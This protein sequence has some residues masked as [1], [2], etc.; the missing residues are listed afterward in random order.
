MN[1]TKKYSDNKKKSKKKSKKQILDNIHDRM[2]RI[3][4]G[5][6]NNED[7]IIA[8]PTYKRYDTLKKKH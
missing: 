7:Y 4:G 6:K 1:K 5:G 2:I 3:V 8:I